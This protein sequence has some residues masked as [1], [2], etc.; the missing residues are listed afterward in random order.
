MLMSPKG[1]KATPTKPPPFT[2]NFLKIWRAKSQKFKRYGFVG[3]LGAG[4]ACAGGVITK[5]LDILLEIGSR[6]F[7]KSHHFGI[8]HDFVAC[9]GGIFIGFAQQKPS[10]FLGG[11]GF[12]VAGRDEFFVLHF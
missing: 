2:I 9:E 11:M 5:H 6:Q 1:R 3:A 8:I 7:V 4:Y 12:C 10:V